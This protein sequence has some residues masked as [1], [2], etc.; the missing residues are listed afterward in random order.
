MTQPISAI[1]LPRSVQGREIPPWLAD[2]Y[3]AYVMRDADLLAAILDD[4]VEWFLTGPVDQFDYYGRRN[5]K[6][7]AIEVVTRIMPCFFRISD[8]EIE[9]LVI[10]GERV[11]TYWQ[12]RAR[13]RDTGRSICF[14]G[15]HF[16]RFREGKLVAF[17]SIAD[18]FDVAE[19]VVGHPIDVNKRIEPVSLAPGEDELLRL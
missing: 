5:G 6:A 11:A 10:Q 9:H 17:R 16:L 8:F 1:A 18:T 2:F 12:L 15:V 19:Q 7:E 3:R 4:E 13:Q 14:R